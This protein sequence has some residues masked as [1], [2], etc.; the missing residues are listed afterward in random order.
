MKELIKEAL[1]F[2]YTKVN[3]GANKK[4]IDYKDI[5]IEDVKL[6]IHLEKNLLF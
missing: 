6:K 2:A 4:V 1:E 5:N 3:R